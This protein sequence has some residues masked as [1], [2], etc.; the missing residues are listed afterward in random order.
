MFPS[1]LSLS[2]SHQG[3]PQS[4]PGLSF[5]ATHVGKMNPRQASGVAGKQSSSGWT[6]I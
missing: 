1:S 5:S 3:F 6:D 4:F 2:L